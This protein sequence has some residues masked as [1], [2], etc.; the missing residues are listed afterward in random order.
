[1]PFFRMILA[2]GLLPCPLAFAQF[3]GLVINEILPN[4]RNAAGLYLDSNQDGIT[5]VFDDE[6]IELLN[7]SATSIDLAGFWISESNTNIRRHVFAPYILPPGG[8]IVVF[9][10]GSL[11]NFSNPPA[12]I[13]TGGGLSLNNN[14]PETVYLF[15]PQTTQVDQVSYLLTASHDA[16]STVRNP[17]GTGTFTNH[18]LSTTNTRRAS[19]GCRVNGEPFLRHQPPILMDLPSQ[20]AFVR[21]ELLFDVRAC[22]PADRD[23]ITLSVLNPPDHSSLSST[24]GRGLFRFTPATDQAG[25]SWN[26]TFLAGDPDGTNSISISIRVI[27]PNSS[28]TLW[29]NEIHYDNTGDDSDEGIEIAGTAGSILSD[30]SLV[31][32]NY[33][34]GNFYSSNALTGTIDNEQ[35]GFGA[36]WFG[37]A[38]NGIQNGPNDGIALV[39]GSQVVQFLSYDGTMTASNGPAAGMTSVDIGVKETG[40]TPVGYS[41]SL[42]GT[43]TTCSAFTWTTASPHSHGTLNPGQ[44]IDC[45]IPPSIQIQKTVYL[46]HDGGASAPGS[47]SVQGTNGAAIT[48]VF[49]VS[50]PNSIAINSAVIQDVSLGMP[51]IALGT[52][53]AGETKTAHVEAVMSG[54]LR[55][56]A[57]VSGQAQDGTLVTD[58]DTAEVMEF[59]PSVDIQLTAYRGQD[60]GASCPG[61]NFLQATNHGPATFCLVVEN[62]GTTN[63]NDL[64]IHASSLNI[65]S[66]PIGTLPSG[67]Q[68]STSVAT[69]VTSSWIHVATVEGTDPNGNPVHDQDSASVEMIQPALQLQKSVYLGHDNGAS[70][71][72]TQRVTGTNGAPLTFCFQISNTGDSPLHH[73]VLLDPGLA[74]FTSNSLGTLAAG[75]S[76]SLFFESVLES[77]HVNSATVTA[78]TAIGDEIADSAFAA[79]ERTVQGNIFA[80]GEYTLFDLGTLGGDS[81]AA[82]G[83]NDLGQVV[84]WA[85]DSSGKTHAFLWQNGSME[86]LGFLP[87]GSNSAATAINNKGEI[88][89]YS[90]LSNGYFHAFLFRS[91]SL[92]DLGTLGGLQ[93]WGRSLN[94]QTEI[95]GSSQL[96]SNNPTSSDPES[97]LWRSNRFTHIPPFH[98]YYSCDGNDVNEAGFVCGITFLWATNDRW[99]AYVF[100]D[101]NGNGICDSGEM[102]LLGTLGVQYSFGSYSGAN[103]I[104]DS[105]QVVGWTCITNTPTPKHAFWVTPTNGQWKIPAGS[106]NPTNLLMKDLGALESP[107][108]NSSANDINNQ[109]WIVGN[110][111]FSSGTNQAVLW[112]NGSIE[113]LNDLIVA[114]TGWVLTDATAIN[115]QNEIVGSG[116]VQGHTR[117][118]LLRKGGHITHVEPQ[119]QTHTWVYTNASSEVVTQSIQQVEEPALQWDGVWTPNDSTFFTVEYC[120]SLETPQWRPVEPASQWPTTNTTWT[121]SNSIPSAVRFFRIRAE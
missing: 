81:S 95:A 85:R 50:N 63:L 119:I 74:G 36:A 44:S 49:T 112:R 82:L 21:R 41:L 16:I 47:K 104:N 87:G 69:C 40:T 73:L 96:L 56:T 35:C 3:E 45:G 99:W 83:I 37:Y 20:T 6:F 51:P 55:N 103:A 108:R 53:A 15:S 90:T 46:G 19:P 66:I 94:G 76:T 121:P 106:P 111:S 93:S 12:Q 78:L 68:F 57:S 91:N 97:F 28:E 75:E 30:Y 32:Y 102:K 114:H 65:P 98:N 2:L 48:F 43:G 89:G 11:L 88:T 72:G 58:E 110:S 8:S 107:S 10:G 23:E 26:V 25:Q 34:N 24:G 100:H 54:D 7:T 79:V 77:S 80:G 115:E 59:I 116:I 29:I 70:F 86:S 38:P 18:F 60:N 17:D 117:A 118:F 120:D 39:K 113:N 64:V 9:G 13:A 33:L 92:A 27:N 84:G 67:A 1:M 42:Q 5:N 52:L 22:D 101:D 109:S 61:S 31:L 4:P 62:N 71:P 105:G 14:D